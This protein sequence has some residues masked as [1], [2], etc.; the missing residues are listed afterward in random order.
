MP[1]HS[2]QPCSLAFFVSSTCFA[3]GFSRRENF[4]CPAFRPGRFGFSTSFRRA[5]GVACRFPARFNSSTSVFKN[6]ICFSIFWISAW[7][8]TSWSSSSA[9][10][11]SF[12]LGWEGLFRLW[13]ILESVLLSTFRHQSH[14]ASAFLRFDPI[15]FSTSD[16]KQVHHCAA[17]VQYWFDKSMPQ[18]LGPYQLNIPHKFTA[19]WGE[20]VRPSGGEN[21][22]SLVPQNNFQLAAFCI[23]LTD[24]FLPPFGSHIL[25][26]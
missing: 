23:L 17:K 14:S 4:P 2:G 15:Q 26:F 10:R 12:I 6:S 19:G 8:R 18:F 21:C 22:S 9:I 25:G 3:A 24:H 1:P 20:P 5:N 11:W 13:L 7:A 16:P